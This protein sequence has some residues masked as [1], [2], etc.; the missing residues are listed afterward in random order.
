MHEE[1]GFVRKL[2]RYFYKRC[3]PKLRTRKVYFLFIFETAS[4]NDIE[5][6]EE[7]S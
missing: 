3:L 4:Y 2:N 5:K 7:G 6:S 1:F